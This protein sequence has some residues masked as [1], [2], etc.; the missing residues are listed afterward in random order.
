MAPRLILASASPRR[1][2]LLNQAGYAF[3]VRAMDVPEQQ[4]VGETPEQYGLRVA[5]AKARAAFAAEPEQNKWVVLAADTEVA[6]GARV[7]GKPQDAADAVR[8]LRELSGGTHL[9]YS[10][11]A[12]VRAGQEESLVQTSK[13]TFREISSC[14]IE[15]YVASG[16][17]F[18][19]AGAY[20][21]QG[22]A[23]AFVRNLQGSYTGVMG[24]PLY[25]TCELLGRFGV[26]PNSP[27]SAR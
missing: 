24:L 18:G 16:E 19:K 25:E 20:A 2:E 8:M 21:I 1:R 4:S 26:K 7:L 27:L 17:P 22:R 9:V 6:L 12:A 11:L 14:E 15:K 23:A 5:L 10:A 13:V 3:A